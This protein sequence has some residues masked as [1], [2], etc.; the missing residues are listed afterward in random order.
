[1]SDDGL[2]LSVLKPSSCQYLKM[3]FFGN[4]IISRC[5]SWLAVCEFQET[6]TCEGFCLP[7]GVT[8]PSIQEKVNV[9]SKTWYRYC[10][11]A[12][13]FW[14]QT[15]NVSWEQ[16]LMVIRSKNHGR[17][18]YCTAC[19]VVQ[20][21]GVTSKAWYRYCLTARFP[22]EQTSNVSWE[23]LLMVI[24][25]INHGRTKYCTAC[26]VVQKKGVIS[27]A[28]YCYCLTAR[29]FWERTPDVS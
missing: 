17:T 19:N 8:L 9:T 29:T 20:K 18:K 26:N 22:W 3:D 21:K 6:V 24:R 14:E 13:F 16:L 12:T 5:E 10:L 15:S 11:T 7:P 1:M 28:W 23:Q 2:T 25:S 4:G 27:K